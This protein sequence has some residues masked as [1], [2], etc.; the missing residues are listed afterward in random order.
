M[1]PMHWAHA[2]S[3]DLVHW[4]SLP[5]ALTPGDQEDEGGCFQEALL[6]NGVLYLFYT[7]HHYY[8]DN[9][10]DHFGKIKTWRIVRMAFTLLNMKNPV[11]AKAPEDNTS[12]QRSKSMETR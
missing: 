3:K 8:G 9:D 6:K 11:I 4:E 12:F 1:G 5:L 7:G 10:P 2:R